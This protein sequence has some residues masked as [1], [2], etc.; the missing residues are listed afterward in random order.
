[1]FNLSCVQTSVDD[2]RGSI[3]RKLNMLYFLFG[4]AVGFPVSLIWV[5]ALFVRALARAQF[6]FDG[7]QLICLT[8]RK[9]LDMVKKD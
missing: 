5:S 7:K 2:L 4:L 1:M 8:C 6:E 3:P 9:V